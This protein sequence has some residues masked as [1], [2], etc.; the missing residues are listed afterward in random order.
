MS[1][2]TLNPV[3]PAPPSGY[4]GATIVADRSDAN[5]VGI[6]IVAVC[7]L[8]LMAALW[9]AGKPQLLRVALPAAATFLGWLLYR[10]QPVTYVSYALWIWFL[11]P[12]VRRIVDWH[13][14]FF[15]PNFVL[16]APLLVSGVSVFSL[17]PSNRLVRCRAPVTFVLCGL[18]VL[19]GFVI[20]MLL[21]PSAEDL[22]G[23]LNWLCPML[24]GLFVYFQWPLYRQHQAA[25]LRTFLW[26]VLILGLYG[27]YQFLIA[28]AW[29]RYWLEGVAYSSNSFGRP[30][31]LEIRVWSTMNSPGPFANAMMAGLLL[32]LVIRS[33]LKL[34]S[35]VA[36]Y[37]SLLL[38]VV[39][40]AWLS[41]ILG[42]LLILKNAKPR[43]IARLILSMLLLVAC[44]LPLAN[45]ARL[46]PVIED[47]FKTFSDLGHDESA[48]ARWDLYRVMVED[49]FHNPF[50]YGLKTMDNTHG[51]IDSGILALVFSLGWIGSV[52]FSVGILSLFL[53]S[54]GQTAKTDEFSTA[55]KAIFIA[56]LAQIVSGPVFV[57]F[58]G[59]LF[60]IFAGMYLAAFRYHESQAGLAAPQ[61]G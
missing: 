19:Y 8:F 18:G 24:L 14:G 57:N 56:I 38:S 6:I 2:S 52:V 22:F 39:R 17:L 13:F 44:L 15:E 23:L 29:D 34:P 49:A 30:E 53:A 46:A 50:G 28:P 60:W 54:Q 59:A 41:W 20:G 9:F 48:G 27:V 26:A 35:A 25:I 40:T 42:F 45:D 51:K 58:T 7:S 11:T 32:L 3:T 12:L 36:G 10:S 61:G 33:P 37:V 47:R 16:L 21:R 43:L 55:A 5:N 4:S 31:P 1:A